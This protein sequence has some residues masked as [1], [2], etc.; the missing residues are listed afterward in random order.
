[1]NRRT[2]LHHTGYAGLSLP[3]LHNNELMTNSSEEKP[4]KIGMIGLDTSHSPAFTQILNNENTDPEFLGFQLTHAYP[5]GSKTIAS[6]YSRI[7]KYTEEVKAMGV[8]ISDS[9]SD[10]LAQV[11]VVLLETNDGRLHLEQAR[12]VINAKKPLFIDKPIAASL[13]DAIKIFEL[14]HE[15]EVPVFSASS[16]R[17]GPAT[18]AVVQGSIGKI[19]GANTY[20]PAKI[21]ATHPDL[22][23]YGV[24]GVEALFTLLGTGCKQVRRFYSADVDVV[25][26][27]WED[28]RMGTFR[29]IRAGKQ[30][31]GGTAF[32]TEGIA[33]AGQYEGYRPLVV[34]I[35]EFFR[36]GIPPIKPEETLEIFAFMAAAEESKKQQGKAIRLADMME[37]ARN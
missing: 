10:L 3:F 20:S 21:E 31:Y 22:F 16:L 28:G 34:E 11:D 5:Y 30:S 37:K 33:E 32:G 12:E 4:L 17:Y 2:F 8:E 19:I 18:Q 1:M 7:P 6:S 27:E 26:G 24:H 36:T 29:G 14:A 23:W 35:A 15:H 25:V 9:I 13:S